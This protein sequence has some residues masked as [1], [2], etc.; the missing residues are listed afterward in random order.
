M[1]ERH[2]PF[3]WLFQ[4]KTHNNN[5]T[6]N[7]EDVIT[8]SVNEETNFAIIEII[9]K[10]TTQQKDE[11]IKNNPFLWNFIKN[12]QK[13]NKTNAEETRTDS[14]NEETNFAITNFITNAEESYTASVNEENRLNVINFIIDDRTCDKEY[15][16]NQSILSKLFFNKKIRIK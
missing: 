1:N 11:T 7:A 13:K 12:I 6:T 16:K 15:K 3:L 4:E 8:N 14:V 9:Y 5:Y 10:D 2:L